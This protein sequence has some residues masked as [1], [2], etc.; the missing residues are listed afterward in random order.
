MSRRYGADFGFTSYDPA[1]IDTLGRT[2]TQ[3]RSTGAT[4]LVLGPAPDP[5]SSVPTCLSGHLDDAD[6]LRADAVGR[7]QR[8]RHRRRAGGNH[9]PAA[10]TTPISPT[11]S[12][13]PTAAR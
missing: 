13:P 2:V 12:A 8:R 4:V 10:A 5:H 3:L 6:R 11:C 1:W 7:G 9:R